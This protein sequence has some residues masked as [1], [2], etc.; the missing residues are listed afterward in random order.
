MI[1]KMST[2]IV[3]RSWRCFEKQQVVALY[4][5]I[6]LL[7]HTESCEIHLNINSPNEQLQETIKKII[8]KNIKVFFYNNKDLE[9]YLYNR[10]VFF[11]VENF[12]KWEW[13]Y[14]ILLYHKLYHENN[15][16]YLL[17]YDDDILFKDEQFPD[18]LHFLKNKIP[19]NIVD[20]Y[21]DADKP[22]MGK[23]VE[24]FGNI[25]F[26]NYYRCNGNDKSGN[27]GFMGFNNSTM[28]FFT[29][30]DDLQ[31][32][33]DSFIYEI[34]DHKSMQNTSWD[35]YKILLQEQSLLSI[36]NRA[37][38][39]GKHII[40]TED[41]G[42]IL[43]TEPLKMSQSKILHYISTLKYTPE[44]LELIDKKY[45]KI[46]KYIQKKI[47]GKVICLLAFRSDLIENG[48]PMKMKDD[49]F[50][51]ASIE[52]I[53]KVQSECSIPIIVLTDEPDYFKDKSVEIISNKRTFFGYTDK[54]T[55]C[56]YAL[57]KYDTAIFIDSDKFMNID[58]KILENI[59]FNE[60]IH[61]SEY[62][63]TPDNDNIWR[64][65]ENY[66]HLK[67]EFKETYL[68]K[69]VN[70]CIDESLEY[71]VPLICEQLIILQKSIYL[72]F[73]KF[74]KVFNEIRLVIEENDR[75]YKNKPVGKTEG[76]GIGI[77]MINTNIKN[78]GVDG[79]K[80]ILLRKIEH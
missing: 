72:D 1:D 70:Y 52:L 43:S 32:L 76:F 30:V 22:M 26:E 58:F 45:R 39:D 15:I 25:I 55:V 20:Q 21:N 75:I 62:W 40:L 38:S 24:K 69:L 33:I 18:I 67:D 59:E 10:G 50:L 66:I 51:R 6:N 28:R 73:D 19:F 53:D 3:A 41:D 13:I 17:T 36:L 31:W 71:E 7:R 9:L 14:H 65:K 29:S 63:S 57:K 12:K 64:F 78:N 48:I 54:M 56:E 47:K 77:A 80:P 42:Y 49:Y 4:E 60:G 2:I 8:P 74:F 61:F 44:Y 35:S 68:K 11:D 37:Y 5:I 79:I 16:D 46:E 34:W 23:L 27:S